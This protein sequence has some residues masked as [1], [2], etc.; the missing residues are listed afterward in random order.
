MAKSVD[1]SKDEIKE[2]SETIL[3]SYFKT[4][5]TNGMFCIDIEGLAYYLHL[6]IVYANIDEPDKNKIGFLSDGKTP[7]QI[8]EKQKSKMKVFPEN[9]IVIDNY[10]R[11][12]D[13]SSE[14]RHTIG[15]EIGHYLLQHFGFTAKE[16]AFIN[17]FDSERSYDFQEIRDLLK[18]D[19]Y[20][21]DEIASQLLMPEFILADYLIKYYGK[22]YI[23]IYGEYMMLSEDKNKL[24]IIAEILGVSYSALLMQLRK[25]KMLKKHSAEEFIERYGI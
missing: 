1:V 5:N 8:I 19:E 2:L 18:I 9:T 11:K 13:M 4:I 7:L 14:R 15:H 16:A 17:S 12:S 10:L 23:N 22:P 24:G 6:N 20:N 3:F 21:A 25:N